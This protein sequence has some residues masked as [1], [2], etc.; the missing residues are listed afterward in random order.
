MSEYQENSGKF[1][2]SA[3]FENRDSFESSTAEADGGD[4]IFYEKIEAPKFVDFTVPDHYR[5]DDRYW[6]CLRVGCNQKHE[7]EMDSEEIYKNFVLR[8]MAAR[9]PNVRLRKAI[10]RN[11]SRTP[12]KCPLSA[13]PKPPKPRLSRMAIISSISK[14]MVDDKK[15]VAKPLLK[16]ASTPVTKTKPVAA[17]YLTTPRIK[18]STSDQNIFRSVRN[19]KPVNVEA[20]KGRVVAKGL[21]FHSPKKAIKV[22]TSVELRTPISK[23]CQGMN[24]L[25]I[26][27][28]RKRTLGCSS[29]SSKN[30]S[31]SLSSRQLS[32][33]KV[34]RKPEEP[35]SSEMRTNREAKAGNS[36]IKG[37]LSQ[38]Q[39][40]NIIE[41][42][43][44]Q[45]SSHEEGCGANMV[46]PPTLDSDLA[47]LDGSKMDVSCLDEEGSNTS[48]SQASNTR[49]NSSG[50]QPTSREENDNKDGIENNTSE[51]FG[52]TE[53]HLNASNS[54][55]G[56]RDG[57]EFMESDDKENASASDAN[58]IHNNN[59]KQNGRKI[60]GLHTKYDQEQKKVTPQ[61]QNKNLKEGSSGPVTKLKKPKA[62]N[63]KPFRLRTDERG[64]LKEAILERRTDS[65][66]SQ[67]ETANVS[68][69]V[70][71]LQRKQG[72]DIQK[73]SIHIGLKTPKEQERSKAARVL[74]TP[75]SNK[76]KERKQLSFPHESSAM[77]RLKR[78]R[79]TT[80]PLPKQHSVRPQG[81][82]PT[83]QEMSPYLIPGQK[84]EVIPENSP[85]VV[86]EARMEQKA[87]VNAPSINDAAAS[88]PSLHGRR[89]VTVAV[90]PRSCTKKLK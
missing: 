73:G 51:S 7:E 6:F 30:S 38:Q 49:E 85:E 5:P 29:K 78:F 33:R 79:K 32:G 70:G 68:T 36:S 22:K 41:E 66:T 24:K 25:E 48:R 17:K 39:A 16:N 35:N 3:S 1:L 60:F 86:S 58:R 46:P 14:K 77:Q 26:S 88:R 50:L 37:Q 27:S 84:L 82:V 45:E 52:E 21:V 4:E 10:E 54:S 13:P 11:G 40:K 9:S 83:K 18:K 63:P 72:N 90:E 42:S 12:I 89:H 20:G 74:V 67:S 44:L 2:S 65:L 28:Q 87:S 56:Q 69:P 43:G 53:V 62:T 76:H 23:L 34:Q 57:Y 80:S 15:R 59:L 75:E 31:N 55:E 71:K 81:V 64:I 8:V 19:P 61:A 47:T